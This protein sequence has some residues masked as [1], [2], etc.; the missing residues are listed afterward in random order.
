MVDCSKSREDPMRLSTLIG[1]MFCVFAL[2]TSSAN[3]DPMLQLSSPT[4]LTTL[5]V[6]QQVEID[7][8]LSGLAVGSDFIFVL[9]SQV[10]F[11]SS[12][13]TPVPD[14]ANSSGLTPGPGF[15]FDPSQ[16]ANFNAASSLTSGSAVG[17]FSDSSPSSSFAINENGL[18]YS[19]ILQATAVG[20]GTIAFNPAGTTYAANDTGFNLAPLP[21]G[22]PLS[23]TISA[24]PEPSSI[25][26]VAVGVAFL[27]CWTRTRK[28][29]AA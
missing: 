15:F 4:N 14:P 6:G 8:T 9:N 17:N 21:T 24:V 22:G 11:P 25:A 26:M 7:V 3:A 2:A 20:S 27:G 1:M 28:R 18:Y 10:L 29:T 5:T 16:V 12:L 23:F 13:F 19:F